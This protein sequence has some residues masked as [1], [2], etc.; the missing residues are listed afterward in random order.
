MS[1]TSDILEEYFGQ[2]TRSEIE[3]AQWQSLMPTGKPVA[4]Y[5]KLQLPYEAPQHPRIP[6]I[7][8]IDENMEN[9][10]FS[11]SLTS[12]PVCR[13]GP[14]VVKGSPYVTI[15]QEAEDL[16]FLQSI[17]SK[18]RTPT[19]YA[20]FARS[21]ND[22]DGKPVE[23]YYM[24]QEYIEAEHLNTELWLSLDITGRQKLGASIAE[25]ILLLRSI[26][27]PPHLTSSYGRVHD[28]GWQENMEMV[29]SNY[30]DLCGPYA[31]YEDFCEAVLT[32]AHIS[33]A[34]FQP[35]ALEMQS[36][37]DLLAEFKAALKT[38]DSTPT[39]THMD[40]GIQ[41]ILVRRVPSLN[42]DG[43]DDWEATLID[44]ERSG[45]F[46]AWVQKAILDTRINFTSRPPGWELTLRQPGNKI[47]DHPEVKEELLGMISGCW[48]NPSEEPRA[49]FEKLDEDLGYD[50]L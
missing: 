24:V 43:E 13:I 31:S 22:R 38:W 3:S 30:K 28:Q 4:Y 45:W 27:P 11:S 7:E 18:L 48:D 40:L 5:S 34:V 44:W 19:V 39:F 9:N 29:Q 25:Q 15:I 10:R 33:A 35:E 46:P 49:M 41:N 23:V 42:G 26:R 50:V 2:Q 20:V 8:E 17:G 12:G 47:T 6:S 32:S 16:L 14:V 1:F 37:Q 36:S 21:M